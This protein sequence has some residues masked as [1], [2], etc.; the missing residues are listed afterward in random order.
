MS[1]LQFNRSSYE[2]FASSVIYWKEHER[3][4]FSEW[5]WPGRFM[6]TFRAKELTGDFET[7]ALDH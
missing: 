1:N 5:E 2:C 4:H 7:Q 3:Q 6:S